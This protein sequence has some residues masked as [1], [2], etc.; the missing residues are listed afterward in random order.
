MACELQPR[1]CKP[2]GLPDKT[3]LQPR[4]WLRRGTLR[5]PTTAFRVGTGV[6]GTPAEM[7]LGKPRQRELETCGQENAVR[8]LVASGIDPQRATPAP[9]SRAMVPTAWRSRTT[10]TL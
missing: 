4:R 9:R 10:A 3:I 1:V 6:R 8:R 5:E 2:L 7:P